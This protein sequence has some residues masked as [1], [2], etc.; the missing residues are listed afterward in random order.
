MDWLF[1]LIVWAVGLLC[2]LAFFAGAR[3]LKGSGTEPLCGSVKPRQP[4]RSCCDD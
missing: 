2:A 4:A 3:R 1:A